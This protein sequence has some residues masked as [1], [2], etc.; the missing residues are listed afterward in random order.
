[1]V[2]L[3]SRTARYSLLQYAYIMADHAEEDD[4]DGDIFI[5]RGGRAPLHV[6]HALIDKSVGE[7][8]EDAFRDC[9]H[10]LHVETHDGIRRIGREAFFGCRSLRR[11]NLKSAVEI[12][13]YA[14]DGCFHM[15]DVEFGN[16][17]ER[18]GAF[19]FNCSSLTHLKLPSSL[20]NIETAAFGRCRLTDIELPQ[21]LERMGPIA[22][23][24]CERL[25]RIAVPLK[26]D[27]F[28]F[29]D[30][31]QRYTQFDTCRELVAVD[32]IGGIHET[33]ASLHME[34]WRTE[35][36]AEI[37]RINQVLPNAR[38]LDK[39]DEIQQW[40][41]VV[42]D[43]IDHYKIEH[44]RYVKEGVTLLELALWKAK[45]GEKKDSSVEGQ[46]KKAKIDS[47]SARK[48]MRTT[49][50]ADTVIKNVLPFL[51]LK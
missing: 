28:E 48:E 35:M 13:D 8:E 15:T 17:L 21:R 47:E 49:C 22:F 30:T 51:E 39:A 23:W 3:S 34:S 36:I 38:G 4:F 25:Q 41:E 46:T 20:I 12:D 7:I 11:I 50:G 6:T 5:F 40:M 10:L 24:S 33:V 32:L 29:S 43:K 14:F 31:W 16:R 27:L 18:I 19:A 44:Y 2:K 1:M 45:L 37:N 9:K 42:I 26:R